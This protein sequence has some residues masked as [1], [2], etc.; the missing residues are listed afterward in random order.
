MLSLAEHATAI[1][2]SEPA[3]RSANEVIRLEDIHKVYRMGE[4]EV[5]ALRGFS[6]TVREG[7]F[8]AIMG[9]S[10]SG[11]STAMNIIGC[12]DQPTHGKYYLNGQ[13]V[14]ELT[15]D[16]RAEIRKRKIGF[17]FQ[18][19]N[20]LARTPAV[21]N[22]ELP[23][24]YANIDPAE[25]HRRAA[26]AL[27]SVG[28]EGREQSFSN[29]LSGGEQQRVAI[30]RALVNQPVLILADEPTGNLDSRTSIEIIEIFQR[31]NREQGITVIVI[32]H[33]SDIAQHAGRIVVFKDGRI[34]KDYLVKAPRNAAGELRG[35][36]TE[37]STDQLGLRRGEALHASRLTHAVTLSTAKLLI[38]F[39][40]AA[41]ALLRNKV[42]AALTMLGIIIGVAA[43]ITLVSIGQGAQAMIQNEI[44]SMGTNL[45]FIGAGSMDAGGV[46]G[47]AA[48]RTLTAD[49]ITAIKRECPSVAL[50]SPSANARAQ[51]VYGGNNWN[52]QI[53]GV[54]EEFPQIRNWQV[55]SGEFLTEA[56]VRKSTRVAVLGQKIVDELFGG[57]NPIGETIRVG[58]LTFQV[59][60][61]MTPKGQDMGGRDQDDVMFAPFT[62]IQKKLL[63]VTHVETAFVSAISPDATKNAEQEITSL[64]R[65]RHRLK[66]GEENDFHVRNL[67][68]VAS[69][70]ESV[71]NI[72]TILLGSIASISLIVGGIGI[73]NIMLV[74][75]TERTREIGIRLAIGARAADVRAQFLIESIVLSM[76]GGAVGIVL[77]A[78]LCLIP[79]LFG[80]S[81]PASLT[82]ILV[83]V[84]FSGAVGISFGYYPARKAANLNP[85]EAL[86]YE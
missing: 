9:A 25:R 86:R 61:R 69:T 85:I 5:P 28:L 24:I 68:D 62:T 56:D 10:G 27:A 4:V 46:R 82:A 15:S 7:E 51:L 36:H 72:L 23:M 41:R 12:L 35:E 84:L 26:A 37:V 14:S 63:A 73:M 59:I 48:A 53:Q 33:E 49:D 8:V 34:D 31:L 70:A 74:S 22:V 42:R 58:E 60:G 83:A 66:T 32:T 19:Y 39:R 6:L 57:R 30:A 21:E 20:L 29:Q 81:T 79:K 52:T 45:L 50:A 1:A 76:A 78:L 17:I 64:L 38:I 75:V 47:T 11:K 71:T 65:Q 18:S 67:S 3:P 77:G 80:W 43:V 44:A 13:D 40:V 54:N 55:A 2:E 16:E